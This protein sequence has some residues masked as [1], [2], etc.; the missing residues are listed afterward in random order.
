M[1][2]RMH[3][4]L[5]VAILLGAIAVLALGSTFFYRK[6]RETQAGGS[7]GGNLLLPMYI[8]AENVTEGRTGL[9]LESLSEPQTGCL[10]DY[11]LT[12]EDMSFCH[13]RC[14]CGKRRRD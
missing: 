7:D 12:P 3:K 8:A 9:R 4:G 2:V 1:R 14:V 11:Q 5:F 6:S 10:H 13:S